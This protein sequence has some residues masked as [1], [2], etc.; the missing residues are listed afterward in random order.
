M[1]K[2]NTRSEVDGVALCLHV[3]Q[4]FTAH[5]HPHQFV[6]CNLQHSHLV[7]VPD[8]FNHRAGTADAKLCDVTNRLAPASMRGGT[9]ACQQPRQRARALGALDAG[10]V[11]ASGEVRLQHCCQYSSSASLFSQVCAPIHD[12]GGVGAPTQ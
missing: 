12:V 7:L 10:F 5:P 8:I 6:V 3:V 1:S 2:V 11:H 9:G 4:T